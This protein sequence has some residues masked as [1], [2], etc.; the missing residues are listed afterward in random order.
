MEAKSGDV[1]VLDGGDGDGVQGETLH[2]GGWG[3]LCPGN[4]RV[5]IF[6]DRIMNSYQIIEIKNFMWN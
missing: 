3:D 4:C 1:G 6:V 5:D 2:R